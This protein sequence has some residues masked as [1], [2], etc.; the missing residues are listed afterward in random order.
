MSYTD[1][2]DK[3]LCGLAARISDCVA[4]SLSG[5]VTLAGARADVY[6]RRSI[7]KMFE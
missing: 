1:E 4:G 7:G 2:L 5:A 6:K 3:S